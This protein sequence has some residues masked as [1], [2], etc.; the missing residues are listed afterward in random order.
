VVA[1]DVAVVKNAGS[2][3]DQIRGRAFG[4]ALPTRLSY[5]PPT[6]PRRVRSCFSLGSQRDPQRHVAWIF[7][8]KS[9]QSNL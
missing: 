4:V 5:D 6:E 7:P 1:A 2:R 8:F 3:L 9:Q